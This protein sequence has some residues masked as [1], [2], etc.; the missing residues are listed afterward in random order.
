MR[1]TLICFALLII[2]LAVSNAV[3]PVLDVTVT[4]DFGKDLGQNFGTLFEAMDASGRAVCGA[5]FAG[6]YNTHF[7]ADRHALQFYIRP[8]E[9]AD[10]F[11][12][13]PLPRP[14]TDLGVYLFDI[15]GAVY[16]NASGKDRSVR[17][18]DTERNEWHATERFP[19]DRDIG[20]GQQMR[21]AGKILQ[22]SSGAVSYDGREVLAAPAAGARYG[23]YYGNGH[24]CYFHRGWNAGDTENTPP[25]LCAVPWTPYQDGPADPADEIT[26]TMQ[27]P[28]EFPYATG[29]RGSDI[30]MTSNWGG[31]HAFDGTAWRTLVA[32][33]EK[34]SYQV[35][36]MINYHDRLLMAQYPTGYLLEFTGDDVITH[37]G[38]PPVPEDVSGSAREAQTTMVYRGDLYCGVWPWAEVWRYVKE[39]DRWHFVGRMFS[40]PESTRETVHPYERDTN[41]PDNVLN[42]WGQR[43]TSMLPLGSSMLIST[44]AKSSATEHNPELY[45][46]LSG[47]KWKEYGMVYSYTMPGNLAATM[48]WTGQPTQLRFTLAEGEMIIRQDGVELARVPLDG[49]S[50]D[51]LRDL[52]V[53]WGRGVFGPCGGQIT[54]GAFDVNQGD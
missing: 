33:D 43:V 17:V 16:A 46:H 37:E 48:T 13:E 42:A 1:H 34:T 24:L 19:A 14:T 41:K 2:S 23:L 38:W 18:W 25:K 49:V 54:A 4:V 22:F 26:M 53:E 8:A 21:V 36:S 10:E 11:T 5:G 52:T 51:A 45:T 35:Y 6:T 40:H 32:A 29:Q 3:E 28:R 7:R 31:V 12:R 47:D 50:A 39:Q 20:A 30:V 44:S 27:F 9:G 15:D